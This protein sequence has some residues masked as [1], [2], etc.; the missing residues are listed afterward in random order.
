[1]STSCPTCRS[2]LVLRRVHRHGGLT[3]FLGHALLVPG[4]LVLVLGSMGVVARPRNSTEL[5]RLAEKTMNDFEAWQVPSDLGEAVLAARAPDEG[6]LAALPSQQRELVLGAQMRLADARTRDSL[7]TLT[8]RPL[9]RAGLIAA[10]IGVVLGLTLVRK[11]SVP[12][13][14]NCALPARIQA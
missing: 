2:Q 8:T 4:I 7:G 14:T 1:M 3:V 13:C 9:F 6:V 12:W 10:A 5:V 11:R